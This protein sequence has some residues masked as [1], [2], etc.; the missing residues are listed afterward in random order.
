MDC[1]SNRFAVFAI[2]GFIA[3][4]AMGCGEK[5]APVDPT[6]FRQPIDDYLSANNMALAIKEIKTGPT[7]DGQT[8]Q[9]QASMTHETLGGPSVTWTFYFQQQ[10]GSWNVT[11]HED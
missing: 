10:E 7:V 2:F 8:A 11:R 6:P 1:T 9:L 5:S 3:A 4:V